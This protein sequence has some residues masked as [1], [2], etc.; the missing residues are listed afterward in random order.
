MSEAFAAIPFWIH[1][2]AMAIFVGSQ[3][4]LA[5]AVVPALRTITNVDLRSDV[6]ETLTRRFGYLGWGSLLLLILT[7]VGNI[8]DR[9]DLY[10]PV[11]VFDFDF[12]YAWLLTTKLIL[13]AVVIVLTAWHSFALGPRLLE[14]QR[15]ASERPS[16]EADQRFSSLRRFSIIVSVVNLLI[17]L[18]IVY[19]VTLM[20]DFEFAFARV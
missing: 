3:F 16:A 1:L 17:A 2:V 8:F 15:A 20:Q 19:I 5:M 13:V 9:Q 4:L 6:M 12:R 7:G 11:G 10:D 14:E 18:A